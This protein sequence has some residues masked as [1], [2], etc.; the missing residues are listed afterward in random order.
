MSYTLSIKIE[1]VGYT[2]DETDT[3]NPFD[4][5]AIIILPVISESV[6]NYY[7]FINYQ[8]YFNNDEFKLNVTIKN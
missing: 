3:V 6:D 5:K 2:E 1:N 8:T 4:P 7:S